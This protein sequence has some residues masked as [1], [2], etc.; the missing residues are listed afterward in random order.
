MIADV[1]TND[2][3][4][5]GGALTVTQIVVPAA[6]GQCT[7]INNL[8]EYAPNGG[9]LGYVS[10]FVVNGSALIHHNAISACTH[11]HS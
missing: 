5:E 10:T 7:V 8:V 6:N 4:P 1:T 3:D 9:F 11:F 2:S